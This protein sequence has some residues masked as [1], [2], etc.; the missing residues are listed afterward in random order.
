M[1]KSTLE[2][3]QKTL[4]IMSS[5]KFKSDFLTYLKIRYPLIYITHNEERRLLQFL[6]HFCKVGGYECYIWDCFRGL[7]DL[8]TQKI[9]GGAE[10]SIKD[11]VEILNYIINESQNYNSNRKAVE[12]KSKQ[13]VKGIIFVLL[14]YFR[15]MD[16]SI[17]NPNPD[18]ER[19]LKAISNLNGIT[20][21]VIT[22]HY[23]TVGVTLQNLIPIIDFPIQIQKRLKVPC[24]K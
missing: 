15:F 5:K 23:Y 6:S 13:G 7:L 2:E 8:E 11:P 3:S 14:D 16:E 20:T 24:G 12:D 22:G 10:E 4:E 1:V 19:R 17:Q 9:A 18:I 21:T